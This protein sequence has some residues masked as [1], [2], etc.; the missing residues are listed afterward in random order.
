[1]P[2]VREFRSGMGRHRARWWK[3]H[4]SRSSLDYGESLKRLQIVL[5][6]AVVPAVTSAFADC[7]GTVSDGWDGLS[8]GGDTDALAP[9]GTPSGSKCAGYDASAWSTRFPCA[10]QTDCTA[11]TGAL[12]PPEWLLTV[13]CQ[14]VGG[15]DASFCVGQDGHGMPPCQGV[16]GSAYCRAWI[17]QYVLGVTANQIAGQC[18]EAAGLGTCTFTAGLCTSQFGMCNDICVTRDGAPRCETPC[19]TQ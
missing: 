5:V 18:D 11:M 14:H 19:E 9:L 13:T 17:S 16:E 7:G 10:T 1:M 4:A 8:Q 6:L 3:K 12:Q 2:S 15:T